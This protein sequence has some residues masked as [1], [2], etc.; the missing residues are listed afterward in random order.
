MNRTSPLGQA[1][2]WIAIL[3]AALVTVFPFYWML[4]TALKPQSE[5]FLSP[6][7][8]YS[9]NWSFDAFR[10]LLI[11]RPFARYFLNSLIVDSNYEMSKDLS[12]T[13]KANPQLDTFPKNGNLKHE[14]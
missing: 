10:T 7:A 2:L 4:N 13:P 5:V 6:P 11:E 8:F 14:K 12:K 3:I 9:A 1:G